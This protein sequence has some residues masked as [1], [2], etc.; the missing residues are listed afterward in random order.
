MGSAA[1]AALAR[2]NARVIAFDRLAPPHT[3]GSSHGRTRIIREAYYEHPLYV[4]LVR[5]AYELWAELEGFANEPLLVQ[6]GGVMA[7]PEKG[8]LFAGAL[9]SARAHRIDHEILS[10]LLL[11]AQYP[12]FAPRS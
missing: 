4:P 1:A 8:P 2:R 3:L 7:G 9:Q 6:T 10:P 11:K 12:A 5:R